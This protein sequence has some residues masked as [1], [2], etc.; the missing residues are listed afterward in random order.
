MVGD[1]I[2]GA[3]FAP[4]PSPPPPA[5]GGAEVVQSQGALLW[6]C[7]VPLLCERL[8]VRSGR[9]IFSLSFAV[10]QVKL[11]SHKSPLQL[12]SGHSGP[13]PTLSNAVCSSSMRA[14]GVLFC[15]EL[16]LGT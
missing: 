9:L 2:F 10:P 4:F 13:V 5:F 1:A 6:T 8:A 16:L 7:S 15:W 14:S 11:L 12:P 3:E